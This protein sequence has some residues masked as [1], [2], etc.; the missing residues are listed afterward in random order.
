MNESALERISHR[1][2]S[3]AAAPKDK[4]GRTFDITIFEEHVHISLHGFAI[5]V[6]RSIK[7]KRILITEEAAANKMQPVGHALHGHSLPHPKLVI[8]S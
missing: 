4:I 6:T 1:R 8:I 2:K 3:A 7:V 5:A